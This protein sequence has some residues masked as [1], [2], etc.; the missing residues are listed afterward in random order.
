[1]ALQDTSLQ[2]S[3]TRLININ[4]EMYAANSYTNKNTKKKLLPECETERLVTDTCPVQH[5]VEDELSA[6]TLTVD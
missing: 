1:M 4:M 6:N 3:T 5:W 2:Y